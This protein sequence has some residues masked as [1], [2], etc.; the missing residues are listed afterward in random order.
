MSLTKLPKIVP[1]KGTV[2]FMA[3]FLATF[4]YFFTRSVPRSNEDEETQPSHQSSPSS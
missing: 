1:S 4:T 2:Y 3:V